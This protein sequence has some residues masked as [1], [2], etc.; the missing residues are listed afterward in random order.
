[1]DGPSWT[2]KVEK[3]SSA[4][5]IDECDSECCGLGVSTMNGVEVIDLSAGVLSTDA[6][7][8]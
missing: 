3:M 7:V 4:V 2:M 8:L 6:I 5:L 1:M